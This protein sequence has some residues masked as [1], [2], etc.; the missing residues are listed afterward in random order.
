MTTPHPCRIDRVRL[1][2]IVAL[3]LALTPGGLPA[4]AA[5]PRD[6][7]SPPITPAAQA[8]S[9]PEAATADP[10]GLLAVEPIDCEKPLSGIRNR[11]VADNE[12]LIGM[13]E[14]NNWMEVLKLDNRSAADATLETGWAFRDKGQDRDDISWQANTAGD[15]DADG[16]DEV[17][18]AFRDADKTLQVFTL[19]DPERSSGLN[20]QMWWDDAHARKGGELS[21]IAVASGNLTREANGSDEVVVAFRDNDKDL[22]LVVLDGNPEG[23]LGFL[24]EWWSTDHARGNVKNVSVAV[25]NLD[26]DDYDDEIVV[27]IE[28]GDDDLQVII[29]EYDGDGWLS[30]K[31]TK[32]WTNNQRGD[33]IEYD[34]PQGIDVTT[35]DVDGDFKD[36]IA[37]AFEEQGDALQVLVLEDEKGGYAERGFWKNTAHARNDVW[38]VSVTAGD[39]DGDGRAEI[40]AAFEDD[41]DDFHV[42]TLDAQDG[43]PE[44]RGSHWD[45][46]GE[47]GNISW[48]DI[49]S[50]DIDGDGRAEIVAA[51]R[52]SGADLQVISFDGE[53]DHSGVI[54]ND[55]DAPRDNGS[56]ILQRHIWEDHGGEGERGDVKFVGV[57]LGDIDGNTSFAVSQETC[58]EV[59]E[60][61]VTAVVSVPPYW[62]DVNKDNTT[63][64]YGKSHTDSTQEGRSTSKSFSSSVTVDLSASFMDIWEAG[65]SFTYEYS[66]DTTRSWAKGT[67]KTVETGF[68]SDPGV[69]IYDMVI[70]DS[71]TYYCYKYRDSVSGDDSRV[72]VPVAV[73]EQGKAIEWWNEASGSGITSGGRTQN[74]DSW[75]PAERAAWSDTRQAATDKWFGGASQGAG[76]AIAKINSGDIPDLVWTWVDNPSGNNFMY[77]RVGWDLKADGTVAS[78]M[79]PQRRAG[80]AAIGPEVTGM[81]AAL[82][83]LDGNARPELVVSWVESV[84]EANRGYYRIGW[85]LDT[86]G[87]ATSWSGNLTVSG[88]LG[89]ETQ[90]TGIAI[91]N[92]DTNSAPDM[93]FGW[94]DNPGGQNTARYKVA[95][96]LNSSGSAASWSGNRNLS[97][98]FGEN[99]VD[100]DLAIAQMD[101]QGGPEL[102]TAWVRSQEN[103]DRPQYSIGYGIKSDGSAEYWAPGQP[104]PMDL[105]HDNDGVAFA[106]AN[107]DGNSQV[108]WLFGWLDDPS[109]ENKA[110]Y[111]TGQL[112]AIGGEVDKRPTNVRE[113]TGAN[114]DKYFQVMIEDK[115]WNMAGDL[116]WIKDGEQHVGP[117]SAATTWTVSESSFGSMSEEKS[118]SH[119]YTIGGEGKVVG[120]GAEIGETWGFSKG[121]SYEISWEDTFYMEGQAGGMRSTADPT[122]AYSYQPFS[123]MQEGLSLTGVGQSYMVVEYIVPSSGAATGVAAASL[124]APA[125][126]PQADPPAAPVITSSTHVAGAWSAANDA[127]LS[128]SVPGPGPAAAGY[129]WLLDT[130]A[131]TEPSP[132]DV[133]VA[134]TKTFQDL[135]DGV[136]Y[137]H[138]RA[139]SDGGAWGP[140][141]RFE[142]KIDA[143]A[144]QGKVT[145]T[146]PAPNA[147]AWYNTPVTISLDASD[148]RGSGLQAVQYSSNDGATWLPYVAPLVHNT[149]ANGIN[150]R[151]RMTDVLGHTTFAETGPLYIDLGAPSTPVNPTC[152]LTGQCTAR[153]ATN[154]QGNQVV[155]ISGPATDA[156]SGVRNVEARINGGSWLGVGDVIAGKFTAQLL[157]EV[158]AGV[159]KIEVRAEDAAG[160]TE[161][162]HYFFDVVWPPRSTPNLAASTFYASAATARP[163]D[164]LDFTAD[165]RSQ[166]WQEAQVAATA[167][168]PAGLAVQA[169]TIS[170]GGNYDAG[171]GKITWLLPYL[172]PGQETSI[173]FQGCVGLGVPAG[174]LAVG[175]ELKSAWPNVNLL[176]L[177]QQVLFTAMETRVQRTA[178]IQVNPGLPAGQ[179]LTLP[180]AFLS[181]EPPRLTSGRDVQL[182][183]A[184]SEAVHAMFIREWVQSVATH[185]WQVVGEQAWTPYQSAAAWQLAAQ[186]GVHYIGV[187]VMDGAGNVSQLDRASLKFTNLVGSNVPLAAGGSVQY[188]FAAQ[189]GERIG[190][191]LQA[192]QGDPSLYLWLPT[193]SYFPDLAR[194]GSGLPINLPALGVGKYLFEVRATTD[195]RY[196]LA[197][198]SDLFEHGA[199]AA[200]DPDQGMVQALSA[201]PEHPLDV[202]DPFASATAVAPPGMVLSATYLPILMK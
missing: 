72:C 29:L 166:A 99:D 139:F 41:G 88:E 102:I 117:G 201:S 119:S 80:D 42:V 51:F 92:L 153:L 25:G 196:Q 134:T 145:L 176:P 136:Y 124:P 128:W 186:E 143:D 97:G 194:V 127:T 198:A 73:S 116:L 121:S 55:G 151:F 115:W 91:A 138:V 54:F 100:L 38:Y 105:G 130:T 157:N 53:K 110:Y 86:S 36:E 83:N 195:S 173:S 164:C 133:G 146:P 47:R 78:W 135:P 96:N 27:A 103:N 188:R 9:Q 76:A 148:G 4:H 190:V 3:L 12:I 170:D 158:G 64:G 67:S 79:D 167:Q 168:A 169:G 183:I 149:N 106:A 101:G 71:V 70:Y 109:G 182:T 5:P 104:L 1:F 152:F 32:W 95:W 75:V 154:A 35:G 65:P 177:A 199:T 193:N 108:E 26:G 81:G 66:M 14:K 197:V 113:V 123:Y 98:A 60:A 165:I 43:A 155:E 94:I 30:E 62:K 39:I 37:I 192:L 141:A 144:P 160:N 159:L 58:Q 28:D 172:W 129:R 11:L 33:I 89:W 174:E 59:R 93:V 19:V 44:L 107:L 202:T 122:L 114:K 184:A 187:W 57:V 63:A 161:V 142:L 61:H 85:N 179:D 24:A 163:G 90:G 16:R 69:D 175:L 140:T 77:Y 52:D 49:D 178:A 111:R 112:W 185:T 82:T 20:W 125:A 162:G 50:G 156:L 74:K 18:S 21:K 180:R 132:L 120:L 46:T 31:Y 189:P 118:Q 34:N 13:R 126:Q 84:S 56:G 8:A 87:V 45:N 171:T 181:I 200:P 22:Q 68:T 40:A 150:Y 10:A 2:A 15:F 147:G 131:A 17:V 137:F 7:A 23:G 48:T 191:A 6:A